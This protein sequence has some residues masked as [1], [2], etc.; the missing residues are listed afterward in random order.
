MSAPSPPA[1]TSRHRAREVALQALFAMELQNRP[2]RKGTGEEGGEGSKDDIGSEL[3]A[4]PPALLA[5]GDVV[6]EGLVDHFEMP[7]AAK[8]FARELVVQISGRYES[9][10]AVVSSHA[11]NWRVSRMAIVDRNILRLATYE[12]IHTA[13]PAAVILDEAVELAR[14]FGAEASPPFVNG[15]LDAVAKEVRMEETG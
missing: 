14:R 9:L 1:P 7:T 10:D 15:V 12:L 4:R 3:A 5:T 13:T 2:A 8:E 11:K 6:F